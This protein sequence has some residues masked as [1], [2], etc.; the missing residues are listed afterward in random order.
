MAVQFKSTQQ[1]EAEVENIG[2]NLA[3]IRE[4]IASCMDE[5]DAER[6]DRMQAD[7]QKKLE[8][9]RREDRKLTLAVIG[10]VKAGKSTFLNELIF[11]GKT[12]LPRAFRPKTAT[13]TRIEY[14]E[15]P[16]MEISYYLPEEWEDLKKLAKKEESSREDVKA[17]KEL[18][19]D[20]ER[21]G[22]DVTSYLTKGKEQIPLPKEGQMESVLDTYVGANG[23]VTPIVKCVTLCI[24]KPELTGISIVDTP[25]TNDPIVSRTQTTK[26]FL[27]ECDVVFFLTAGRSALDRSDMDLLQAQLPGQGVGQIILVD[28]KFD[29]QVLDASYDYD[30]MEEAIEGEKEK[31]RRTAAERFSRCADGYEMVGNTGLA[32]LMRSCTKPLFLSSMMHHMHKVGAAHYSE[33]ETRTFEIL[34]EAHGDMT[35]DMVVKLGDMAP[36]EA[37]FQDVITHKDEKLAQS[38][39]QMLPTMRKRMKTEFTEMAD[40]AHQQRIALENHD[41]KGLMAERKAME[42]Q[43]L[44]IK[45]EISSRF[46]QLMTDME[47]TKSRMMT[48]LNRLSAGYSSLTEKTGTEEHVKHYTVSDSHWY[49]PFS[50]GRSHRESYTYTTSYKYVE[51][52]DALESLRKY[53]YDAQGLTGER[54][55]ESIDLK[56]LKDKLLQTIVA[57]MDTSSTD[58]NPAQMRIIVQQALNKIELPVFHVSLDVYLDG[59]SSK[60]SGEIREAADREGLKRALAKSVEELMQALIQQ[61]KEGV[62]IFKVQM[63]ELQ[64]SFTDTLLAEVNGEFEK[65]TKRVE[66]K[67]KSIEQLKKYEDLLEKYSSGVV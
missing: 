1:Q 39:R 62:R 3:R 48:E 45:G 64:E 15:K 16:H 31:F 7:F 21:S 20:V 35:K 67:E 54:M 34:D 27:S 14:D 28:S 53:A 57:H 65:L 47:E 50:W 11:E 42:D 13:L 56:H 36:I 5:N 10:R 17:A 44:S 25:G 12:I 23:K 38:V 43:I 55:A 51:A 4:E 63:T 29:E 6:M 2:R 49:N 40:R 9:F 19:G 60:F 24:D 59:I 41:K 32:A 22:L 18:V 66:E 52:S 58:F 37:V 26:D 30:S 61:V 8:K 46:G 33:A